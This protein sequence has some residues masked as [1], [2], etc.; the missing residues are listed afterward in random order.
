[1]IVLINNAGILERVIRIHETDPNEWWRTYEVNV[2]GTFLPTRAALQLALAKPQ[3][4]VNLTIINTSSVGSAAT[5][6]GFSSYQ[7]GKSAINR[8]TEF[9]HFEYEAEG[10]RAFA[11]HPGS[12]RLFLS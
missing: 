3:R 12:S 4:P 6:P 2:R 7:P 1:M 10:V 11:Y 9:I 8:F 5:W